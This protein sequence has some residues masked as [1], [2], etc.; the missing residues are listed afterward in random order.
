MTLILKLNKKAS[1]FARIFIPKYIRK[2]LDAEEFGIG[3][4][5]EFASKEIKK[6]ARVLDAGAGSLPYKDYF[7]HTVYESTDFENMFDSSYKDTHNFICSLDSIPRQEGEYDAIINTQVLEHVEFPQK[8]INE[9]Y[10]VLK[11]GGKLF[12]TAPQ[13]WGVHGAPYHFF[14]FTNY[15]L[16]SLFKK[17][18]FRIKFIRPRGGI[19]WYLGK[20]MSTLPGYIFSQYVL[21]KGTRQNNNTWFASKGMATLLFPLYLLALPV[22]KFLIPLSFFYLDR[23][24]KIRN[25]TL[26]YSCYCIK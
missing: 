10:R 18:G 26:G 19:F 24:D 4:F 9:F 8:V 15:G 23:L 12:L 6:S 20:R 25:Y 17:A 7:S 11:P 1:E 14:N 13:G 21:I 5:M 3:K 2:R 22:C 16:E